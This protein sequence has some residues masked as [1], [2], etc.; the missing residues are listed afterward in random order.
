MLDDPLSLL[1][2]GVWLM[3]AG[4]WP[5]GFLFGACSACCDEGPCVCGLRF[6]DFDFD[7][8]NP[9]AKN[10]ED[11]ADWC[12]PGT[13][14]SEI[15]VRVS[16]ATSTPAFAGGNV[17]MTPHCD[18]VEGDY[19]LSLFQGSQ[20][21]AGSTNCFY[22]FEPSCE[23]ECPERE[24]EDN[25]PVLPPVFIPGI[26][27]YA[28]AGSL[29]P[30]ALDD[31]F[32][33]GSDYKFSVS[34]Y[35]EKNDEGEHCSVGFGIPATV[36]NPNNFQDPQTGLGANSSEQV[37]LSQFTP[38]G[39]S[40]RTQFSEQSCDMR[41]LISGSI[42]TDFDVNPDGYLAFST[43]NPSHSN[44]DEPSSSVPDCD[45]VDARS[46]FGGLW[47]NDTSVFFDAFNPIC[48]WDI[49]ILAP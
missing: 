38:H 26:A 19:V 6:A 8:A 39:L 12:C 37:I 10:G 18:E 33:S 49:E 45:S 5:V 7:T 32:L 44:G 47:A 34:L 35:T 23:F 9:A 31:V 43:L 1:S 2:L 28:Y 48:E 3:A 25:D 29:S 13:L 22:A 30:Y 21:S 41:G 46:N 36:E 15:T 27:I 11:N 40:L 14:P 4:M 42:T 16:N 20:M 17:T 24:D